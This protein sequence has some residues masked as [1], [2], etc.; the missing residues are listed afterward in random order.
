[1]MAQ[2]SIALRAGALEQDFL[3]KA[4]LGAQPAAFRRLT[5]ALPDVAKDGAR[6]TAVIREAAERR[7]R[8]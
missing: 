8:R 5:A 6:R 3:T 2:P 7:E 4:E 1:M